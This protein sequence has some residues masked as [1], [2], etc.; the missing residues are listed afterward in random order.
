[1]CIG[2]HGAKIGIIIE[3]SKKKHKKSPKPQSLRRKVSI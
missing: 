1:M 2:M 3:T